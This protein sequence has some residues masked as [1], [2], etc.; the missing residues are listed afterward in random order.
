MGTLCLPPP[1]SPRR[2]VLGLHLHRR[3]SHLLQT[4]TS[5]R[6]LKQTHSLLIR[7]G[8]D[9]LEPLVAKLLSFC[10]LSPAGSLDYARLIFASIDSPTAHLCNILLRGFSRSNSPENAILLYEQMRNTGVSPDRFSFPPLLKAMA[11]CLALGEGREVHG[12]VMK[13][14]F[15]TDVFIHNEL[16]QL[17][18]ECGSVLDVRQVFEKMPQRNL[19]TW[20][21]F[22]GGLCRRG[23]FQEVVSGF[24]EMLKTG[25]EPD[26]LILGTVIS[27]CGHVKDL[28]MG[29]AVHSY[30]DKREFK[31]DSYLE[32]SLVHMY[33]N[34]GSLSRAQKLFDG[35]QV[36]SLA[37]WT[38]LVCGYCKTG[39]V[40][41]AR[42][43]FDQMPERDTVSWSAMI[44]GYVENGQPNDALK[45]FHE[46]QLSG[47]KL[48]HITLLSVLSACADLGAI[49]Q[50]RWIHFFIQQNGF[51]Q[52]LSVS[53]A[54]ID[55][56][57]KCGSLEESRK[58]FNTMPMKNVISWTAMITGLAMHGDGKAALE[59]FFEMKKSNIKPNDVT[60]IGVLYACSHAGLVDE[61]RR[62]FVEMTK[63]HGILPRQEHYGC[64]V[65]LL[66]RAN[67]LDDA[68][69]LVKSMPMRPNVIIWGAL[70]AA[71]KIH[72]N[73]IMGEYAAKQL[74]E[75]NPEH[76]GAYVM[77]SNIYASCGRWED[78]GEMRKLMRDRGVAKETGYSWVE[79]NNITHEFVMGDRSHPQTDEIYQKLHQVVSEVK[80]I[81][82][83]P[84]TSNVLLNVEEEEKDDMLLLHSEKLAVSFGLINIGAGS[85][86]RIAKNL[87]ICDDCHS[88]MK[89]I[90]SAFN[91][92]VILRDRNRFH[93]FKGGF[94]SCRDY[95]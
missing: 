67:L 48:D 26:E 51:N 23:L 82:Y 81:G 46:M 57:A 8:L 50:G 30:I 49:D 71:C 1:P 6:C 77:L 12:Y 53:N 2:E 3:C 64:M 55:M 39:D 29:E 24:E 7:T 85:C 21:F 42:L 40:E 28:R 33:A 75:L 27:A 87:R 13:M 52:T 10:A 17:Y 19:V 72:K 76:D 34:C 84:N 69:E 44:A 68:F 61:G 18:V 65:D 66:G 31:I 38:A 4:C 79:F 86:I 94:C 11:Q 5:M 90:S 9:R 36:K 70:A 15:E 35:M 25:I 22:L 93:H 60:F 20:D 14:G 91:R 45:L 88:F 62:L 58:V 78:V 41:T 59:L 54:L 92:E 16:L 80:L 32:S 89:L 43:L 73:A 95:W 63:E 37:A 74:L 83:A 47:A 56:Y